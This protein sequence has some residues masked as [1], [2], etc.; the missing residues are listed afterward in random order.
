MRA[1][2]L[3]LAVYLLSGLLVAPV[4]AAAGLD[5]PGVKKPD[6]VPTSTVKPKKDSR[7]N[8][9]AKNAWKKA[10]KVTWPT[11]STAAVTVP[12]TGSAEAASLP[13]KLGRVGGKDGKATGPQRTQV[14]VLDRKTAKTLGT[15]GLLLAVRT[16]DGTKG[17]VSVDLDYS[18]FR[19][20]YGG[21]WASRLTLR[22]LPTCA[23]TTPHAPGCAQGTQLKTTND[24]DAGTLTAT[25]SLPAA[26]SPDSVPVTQAPTA[27][28]S[29]TGM[30]AASNTVLLVATAAV[31]GTSGNFGATSLAPSASWAAGGSNG[32]FTWNYGITTPDVPGGAAPQLGLG[33]SS[34][35][36][37]GRTAATN[38]QANWIGDGWSMEPGY[39]ERQY[40]SCREDKSGSNNTTARVGDLCWKK[41]NAVL[42]L[43]GQ[44]N[45]LVK[46]TS[47]GAWHLESD[48]GTKVEKLTSS[49]RGNG[50]D[51]GEYWRVTTPDGT[52]YYFGY[53][54]L[55]GWAEG[56]PETDSTWTVPVFGNH[57]GEPC[58]NATFKD[59]WC[60][61]AW[62][63]NLDYVVDPHSDAMAYYWNSE[64]NHYGRNV[65]PSTGAST[66]TAYDR[67]GYL[68]RIE[69]GLRSNTMY[70]KKAAGKVDFTVSE[71]CLTDCSTFNAANAQN[72]PDVPFDQYCASGTECKDRY[73]PS[74]WS[75]KRLTHIDTSILTGNVYKPVDTWTLGHQFPNPGDG[76][77]PALWLNSITRTGHTGTGDVST[78]SV[79][80][81][82]QTLPN[83]VEGATTGG[84]PDPVPPMW[85]YRVYAIDTE[86]G[87]TIGVTYSSTD[88][89]AGN[90][91]SPASNTRRCYPVIWSPPDAPDDNYE[92][93]LD[94]FHTYAV[95]Q[96]L[97]SDNTGGAPVKQTDYTYLGGMAWTKSKDD[98]FTKAKHL[99]YSDRKGYGRVQVRSGTGTDTRT[100]KEYRYFRGVDGAEVKD[101]EGT[102]IAD[103][104]AFAGM[105]R[106]EATYTS[107]GGTLET[108][109]SH[110]PWRSPATAT[111]TRPEGLPPR[112]SYATGGKSEKT[113]TAVGASWR[114]TL[115]TRTFDALGQPLTESDLGDT[116]E[117]GDETCTNTTYAQN[118][119]TNILTLISEIKTVAKPCGTTPSLPTDLVSVERHYYDGATSL[120]TAPTKGDVTRL[121]EQDQAGTGYLTTAT[122]TYD[123]HGRA[124]TETDALDGTTTTTYTPATVEAPTS[125]TVTNPLGHTATTTYEPTRGLA[126]A[127]IDANDKRTDAVHD[128]LGR[129]LKVWQPGWPKAANPSKPSMEYS[130]KTSKTEANAVTTK[131]LKSNGDYRTTYALYDGLLRERQTQA[132]AIGTQH[133]MVTETHYDTRGWAWKTYGAYYAA[134]TPS[135]ALFT[136]SAVN[137]VPAA[138]ENQFDGL[139]RVT[140]AKSLKYGDEQKRI[141]TQHGGDRITVIPPKGGTATTTVTDAKGRTTEL[142]QYTNAER[143]TSHKTTYGYGKYDEPTTVTDP[144]G[145]TWTYTFDNRGQKTRSDDPDKGISTTTYDQLGR[146]ATV[147]DARGT[148]LTT[149]YDKLGRKI[150][151]KHG[152]TTLATWTYDTLAKG[153]PTNSTRYAGGAQYT[154]RAG[155]YNDRYQPTS[156]TLAVPAAAGQLEGDYTWTYGYDDETG[157]RE[158]TMN[159]AIGGLTSE[160]VTTVLTDSDLPYK[161]TAGQMILANSTQYDVHAR[162]VRTEYGLLGKKLYQTQAY[163]EHTGLPTRTTTDRDTAPQRI[164]DVTYYRNAADSITS[165]KTVSGQD[166]TAT[167]DR[168]CFKMDALGQ[169]TEAFTTTNTQCSTTT[170]SASTVGG[171]DAYWQTF[172]YDAIGNRTTE[173][174]HKATGG[175]QT[176]DTTRT[177]TQPAPGADRPH[178]TTSVTTTGGATDTFTYDQAGNMKTRT[179]SG[180]NQTLTWNPEGHLQTIAET[181]KTTTYLYDPQGTRLLARNSDN[182]ATLYLPEGNELQLNADG[183][184]TA[185]RYYS[186]GAQTI[187]MRTPTTGFTFLFGDHQGTALIAVA[188]TTGQAITRR[189]QL[190]FGQPRSA[191]TT[192]F[193]TRGFV[194]GTNDPTGLTHLGAREYDPTLGA[195]IS[196]DP[197]IDHNDPAQMH[198][199]SYAHNTP[200]TKS[201]PDGLRP[202]PVAG[203]SDVEEFHWARKRGM[204]VGYTER[205]GRY[206]WGYHPLKD[207][208][209][210]RRYRT[211]QAG[212]RQYEATRAR[213]EASA[214]AQAQAKRAADERARKAAQEQRK[215]DG[216]W[217]N[218]LKGNI[219][220][221]WENGKSNAG[222]AMDYVLSY[223]N[224]S[225]VCLSVGGSF[226]FGGDLSGCFIRTIRPDG[227]TDYG[228]SGTFEETVG[229][230]A[231]ATLGFI[232]SNADSFGQIR[233]EA[234][235]LGVSAGDGV[236]VSV[237]HRGTFGTRNSRGDIV[238]TG[239]VGF[240]LGAGIDAS[241]GSGVTGITKLWTW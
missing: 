179:S 16:T 129:T 217:G 223:K 63:W 150:A 211:Y 48:D 91:P 236:M 162:P 6:P 138:T 44:S 29:A 11:P 13:V 125:V 198:A 160:R 90:V 4:A 98:E 115:K 40:I 25:V 153:Q 171:P 169:L 33:Y 58:Y 212:V 114:T 45:T 27:A 172:T 204:R 112:Y 108:T 116:A 130:Y 140:V 41:D 121:E 228:L 54:R 75:R 78:P 237:S 229:V 163:D 118:T 143:T 64:T 178:A 43:G 197:I 203:T 146:P 131:T 238:H 61:Q 80:F 31:S 79:T 56:K 104:E 22:Q 109:T 173:V 38:N 165:I 232:N 141:T 215:R 8:H 15:E 9:A 202:A 68:S 120:S 69:Y 30:S 191:Q 156:T 135:T 1:V 67:G 102:A 210:Q 222:D 209:S 190:P 51:N 106:E 234:G 62:R 155:G 47:S 177:Y 194:G 154:T 77:A 139:G 18:G 133:T 166:D 53:N 50:D 184:T 55:P 81:R 193:G 235:G 52:R 142:L 23:L 196:V 220:A 230:G 224:T 101:S 32:G 126:T 111:E 3:S 57:S 5:L 124:L 149:T 128:G 192:A 164:D 180:K 93:Y 28:R 34:Q 70:G 39:I 26:E 151:I 157:L 37:D 71:R 182:T 35:S 2:A 137:Q 241:F 219:S 12:S 105:T 226:G 59:A 132:P 119:S 95:T 231:G 99:T 240:G 216:I 136:A 42:N 200:L 148:T 207:P 97:E 183:T 100:L 14:Q 60:Q 66:A 147:T 189:K 123:Q 170:P 233:G 96:V 88:C 103:H 117:S 87:G 176:T 65:N 17:P 199:Y 159:P 168:Q 24:T 213:A 201:D 36:V 72:W 94:W 7:P 185:T 174:N 110:E 186:H 84:E 134:L 221:A 206:V 145:N 49:N 214:R 144:A 239:Q 10:P 158:W 188:A 19:H 83:R 46:D 175:T 225:G 82:G 86:T 195:F 227:K 76:T 107:D 113:R 89:A 152:T 122:H 127:A 73:S 181:G 92:P 20:A 187:A 205:N 218:I 167:T 208:V 21:D 74:F 85:R 161:T